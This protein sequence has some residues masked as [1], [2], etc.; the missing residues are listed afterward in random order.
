MGPQNCLQVNSSGPLAF[1]TRKKKYGQKPGEVIV[2]KHEGPT[3]PESLRSLG[4]H[5]L[6]NR[7]SLE[8]EMMAVIFSHML[9]SATKGSESVSKDTP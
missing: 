1:S 9:I 2:A 4:P 5:V 6:K 3:V 7:T 8:G